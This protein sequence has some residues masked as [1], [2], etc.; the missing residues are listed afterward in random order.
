MNNLEPGRPLRHIVIVGDGLAAWMAAAA[1]PRSLAP[2]GTTVRVL[3]TGRSNASLAPLGFADSTLPFSGSHRIALELGNDAL[4]A[5]T[6][7]SFT[8]GIAHSGWSKPGHTWFHPFGATGANLGP[9]GF[10][11]LVMR[12]RAEGLPVRP[13]N[14]SLSA[15]AAQA[16]RFAPPVH[17]T[18]SVLSTC[19]FGLHLD[20][21]SLAEHFRAAA[22]SRG[23]EHVPGRLN[24]VSWREDGG[25]SA[26]VTDDGQRLEGDLFLDCSGIEARLIGQYDDAEWEDWSTWLP[27]DRVVSARVMSTPPPLPYSHAEA[28]DCGWIRHLPLQ[29]RTLLTSF[30]Q[31]ELSSDDLAFQRLRIAAG[32]KDLDDIRSGSIRFGRRKKPWH[33]NCIALGSAAAIIDPLAISN[34]HLLHCS[35]DRLLELLPQGPANAEATEYNRLTGLQLDRARDFAVLHYRLNGRHGEPLWDRCR[36]MPV[37]ELLDYKL[38]LYESRGRVAMYDEEPLE[39]ASWHNLLSELGVQPRRYSAM[40]N[41]FSV[42][43][44]QAH[45]ARVRDLMLAQ[46]SKMPLHADYLSRL[47]K[48]AVSDLS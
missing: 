6:G 14:Y 35:I 36:R 10:H 40:V 33:R 23:V 8:Y 15:L 22:A 44:L 43:E 3:G 29:G 25:I 9:V 26:V 13:A 45:L 30:H 18:T 24:D 17:D 37:P 42:N 48:S 38:R 47:Q 11:Q 12:L 39:E 5:A 1:L 19:R 4:V 20:C 34:L 16:Q 31:A 2:G 32:N 21:G 28:N 46:V 41:Q 27:C 7:G